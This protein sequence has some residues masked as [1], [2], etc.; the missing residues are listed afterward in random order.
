MYRPVIKKGSGKCQKMEAL[1]LIGNSSRNEVFSIAMFD[2]P[3]VPTVG[4][5][6]R[7]NSGGPH[8][9]HPHRGSIG[10][11]SA[12]TALRMDHMFWSCTC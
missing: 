5:V 11:M 9:R 8:C 10:T 2:D 6:D 3:R 1:P 7:F 12:A 4:W